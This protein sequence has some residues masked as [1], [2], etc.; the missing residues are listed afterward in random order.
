MDANK[1]EK[2]RELKY[3]IPATCGR[4]KFGNFVPGSVW[5]GCT[6]HSYTHLKHTGPPKP[7]SIHQGGQCDDLELEPGKGGDLVAFLEFLK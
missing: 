7:L 3:T 1:L 2:L 6:K 4:C 5:G